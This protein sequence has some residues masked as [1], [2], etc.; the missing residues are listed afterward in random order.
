MLHTCIPLYYLRKSYYLYNI[1][2]VFFAWSLGL[3]AKVPSVQEL[4]DLM[5]SALDEPD[6]LLKH[7]YGL[8]Q[9]AGSL[10]ASEMW[11]EPVD[12]QLMTVNVLHRV[13]VYDCVC[14]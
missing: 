3:V 5:R 4:I 7:I 6:N 1:S 13:D 11:L 10:G 2:I 12:D 9:K 8:E 14:V